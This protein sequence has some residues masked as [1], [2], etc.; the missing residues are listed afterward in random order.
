MGGDGGQCRSKENMVDAKI[1]MSE[2]TGRCGKTLS[3][4]LRIVDDAR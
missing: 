4:R 2:R 3:K 1:K